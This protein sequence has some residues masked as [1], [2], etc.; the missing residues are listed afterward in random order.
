MTKGSRHKEYL[1]FPMTESITLNIL[2]KELKLIEQK[3][4]TK[5]ELNRM[6]ETLEILSNPSTMEQLR[7]SE[8]EISLGKFKEIKSVR[9][10]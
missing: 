5:E 1:S 9:D 8:K 4:A 2:Y 3:M 10:I 7:E 6:L